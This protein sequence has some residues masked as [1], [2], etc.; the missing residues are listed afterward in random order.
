MGQ[1]AR[2]TVTEKYNWDIVLGKIEKV[3]H[4]LVRETD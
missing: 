2:Q 4:E 3:Y 1:K